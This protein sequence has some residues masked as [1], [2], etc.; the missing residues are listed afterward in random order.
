MYVVGVDGCKGGWLGI[1][2]TSEGAWE[3]KVFDSFS[4][5]W[6][7]YR[8]AALILVDIPIG[9]LDNAHG[10]PCDWLARRVLGPRYRSV[11]PVPCRLAIYATTYDKAIKINEKLTKKRVFQATWNIV[12]KIRQVEELL[13]KDSKA[14]KVIREVH[15]EVLFWALA[16]RRPMKFKKT[17]DEGFLERVQVLQR[18]YPQ[19]NK[20]LSYKI[21]SLRPQELARDDL[22]DAL[23]AAVTAF[24][25]QGRLAT[26]PP[27]PERD[28]RGLPMEMV[29]FIPGS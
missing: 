19:T 16:G 25:G 22:M 28:A 13:L 29:Y 18:I 14:R 17:A 2:L 10:R 23:A 27:H 9:L 15:P 4:Q 26:L 21:S 12:P 8:D 7:A 6:E 11:F 1:K 20:M 24:L 5:L 3:V